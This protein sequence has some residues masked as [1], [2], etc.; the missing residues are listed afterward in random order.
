M[1][2]SALAIA[3]WTVFTRAGGRDLASIALMQVFLILACQGLAILAGRGHL[4]NWTAG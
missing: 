1:L 3:G 2:C 4:R